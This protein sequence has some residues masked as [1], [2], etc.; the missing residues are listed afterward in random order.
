MTA[1]SVMSASGRRALQVRRQESSGAPVALVRSPGLCYQRRVDELGP[2]L[3]AA[4]DACRRAGAVIL[5]H[6][7]AGDAEPALKQ[8]HSPIT[9]ADTEADEAITAILRARFPDDGLL[10]EESADGPER[11]QRRFVWV[12]DP[13]DGT[14]DFVARTGEF[15]VHVGL[16][17]AGRPVLGVVYRPVGDI[18]YEAVVG[19]G[20]YR[21]QGG[22]RARL[23]VSPETDLGRFRVGVTRFAP[24]G[25]LRRFLDESGLGARARPIGASIK[26][27]A[28]AEGTIELTACVNDR[29]NEWDTCAPEV[30][31]R[32]AG[33]RA[34]DLR[35]EEFR[36][37]RDDVRHRHGILMSNGTRHGELLATLAPYGP[38]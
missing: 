32:E 33:G 17:D 31:V 38:A 20:A 22:A 16:A 2:R 26:M 8:D 25:N 23:Q 13:L 7:H 4:R 35:G 37:N 19:G 28:V 14:R 3:E 24:T 5:A 11:R 18:L 27:M 1:V 9:R 10:T 12:V 34:T 21:E 36:Y 15:A 6:Y 29:E 30:I